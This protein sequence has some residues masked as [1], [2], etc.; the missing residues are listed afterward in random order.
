ME[1]HARTLGISKTASADEVRRAYKRKAL[2]H[3]PDRGGDPEK[4]KKLHEAME[5]MLNPVPRVKRADQHHT[6]EVSL[7]EAYNG[8]KKNVRVTTT[9]AC[10]AC[11]GVCVGCGGRGV[12]AHQMCLGPFSQQILIGCD[13]CKGHGRASVGCKECLH[14]GKIVKENSVE[15][16]IPKGSDSTVLEGLGEQPEQ[17]N[18][19]PGNLV[20]HITIKQHPVFMLEKG[21]NLIWLYPISFEDSVNG[22]KIACP[23]L[24][25]PF[26]VDTSRWGVLDP[27]ESYVVPKKGFSL[28]GNLKI[29]FNIKYPSPH[30]RFVLI[31]PP[32][33]RSLP[34]PPSVRKPLPPFPA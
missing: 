6:M 4:F 20:I 8:V 23:H 26:V 17:P 2:E 10:M 7:E 27:R 5:S 34:A 16:N 32:P 30:A 13:A 28:N 29:I 15:I 21:D 25:G 3:H 12:V 14:T 11:V 1:G 31:T 19:D 9:S 18:E 24:D 22:C 33:L